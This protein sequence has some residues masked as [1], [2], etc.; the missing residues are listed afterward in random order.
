VLLADMFGRHMTQQP[1]VPPARLAIDD[2][3]PSSSAHSGLT[4]GSGHAMGRRLGW[5]VGLAVTLLSA[6]GLIFSGVLFTRLSLLVPRA[7][8][9][10]L[11]V[12]GMFHRGV[13]YKKRAKSMK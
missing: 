12:Q 4:P 7:Q 9:R 1:V 10:G 2:R 13:L 8:V 5:V 6:C 3:W 11:W